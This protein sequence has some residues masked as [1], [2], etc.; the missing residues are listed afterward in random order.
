VA[1]HCFTDLAVMGIEPKFFLNY[2]GSEEMNPQVNSEIIFGMSKACREANCVILGG[3]MA[4][5]PD[6]FRKKERDIVGFAVGFAEKK[7]VI[8][9]PQIIKPGDVV[10][11]ITANGIHLNG[12]SL[13]RRKILFKPFWKQFIF[14]SKNPRLTEKIPDGTILAA[15]LLAPMPNYA[16]LI[17]ELLKKTRGSRRKNHRN[18]KNNLTIHGLAHI[19]GGGLKDNIKRLLPENCRAKIYKAN[20]ESPPIFSY[21]QKAGRLTEKVMYETFNM[22]VGFVLIAPEETSDTI[23]S[24]IK[25]Q[26]N[27][28]K[29][30]SIGEITEGEKGVELI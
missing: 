5:M 6:I 20:I 25:K 15:E 29:A 30:F 18:N 22:G 19:T 17:I 7:R 10:L 4:Q 26:G 16:K 3:E 14:L 1:A 28:L 2:L 13:V 27:G 8:I 9:A 24:F 11:G 21:L 12:L 23:R